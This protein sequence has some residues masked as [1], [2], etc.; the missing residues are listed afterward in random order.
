METFICIKKRVNC[1]Y[2]KFQ[3]EIIRAECRTTSS[4]LLYRCRFSYSQLLNKICDCLVYLAVSC[5][6]LQYMD[7]CNVPTKYF[8]SNIFFHYQGSIISCI[9]SKLTVWN[10]CFTSW[11]ST[12]RKWG[13]GRGLFRIV[14]YTVPTRRYAKQATKYHPLIASF[15]RIAHQHILHSL[16]VVDAGGGLVRAIYLDVR[17]AAKH[18]KVSR[19]TPSPPPKKNHFLF[20]DEWFGLF[21]N[22]TDVPLFNPLS[23]DIGS[24]YVLTLYSSKLSEYHYR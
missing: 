13:G 21:L 5:Q 9:F 19:S 20:Q 11:L 22:T 16:M 23:S 15:L 24:N 14:G 4:A 1:I 6:V 12:S 10:I 8:L 17:N 2:S 7:F 18:Y 3:G